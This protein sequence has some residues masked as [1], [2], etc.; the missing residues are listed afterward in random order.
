MKCSELIVLLLLLLLTMYISLSTEKMTRNLG[1][2][3]LILV[4][5]SLLSTFELLL[6]AGSP[7]QCYLC[8]MV[9]TTEARRQKPKCCLALGPGVSA[10]DPAYARNQ[11][12]PA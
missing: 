7:W 9:L 10:Q 6:A 1:N 11:P 12:P 4:F 2:T 8:D 5:V 3:L